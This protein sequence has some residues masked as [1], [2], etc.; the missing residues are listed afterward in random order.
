MLILLGVIGLSHLVHGGLFDIE[1]SKEID[2]DFQGIYRNELDSITKEDYSHSSKKDY[3]DQNKIE[4]NA[5]V[6]LDANFEGASA[7]VSNIGNNA[8]FAASIKDIGCR[9][10]SLE[11]V[12]PKKTKFK[13]LFNLDAPTSQNTVQYFKSTGSSAA[14]QEALDQSGE[15]KKILQED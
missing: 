14:R 13:I 12:G 2:R 11:Y 5:P 7:S 4:I 10:K 9:V 3:L 6:T 1:I 8:K 15:V